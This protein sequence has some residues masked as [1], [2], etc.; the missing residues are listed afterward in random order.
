MACR[1]NLRQ[2][3][4]ALQVY[5]AAYDGKLPWVQLF[6]AYGGGEGV[7][8]QW[9]RSLWSSVDYNGITLCPMAT[10]PGEGLDGG[11]FQAWQDMLPTRIEGVDRVLHVTGSYGGNRSVGWRLPGGWLTPDLWSWQTLLVKGTDEI[12]FFFDCV[13]PTFCPSTVSTKGKTYDMGLPPQ[14]EGLKDTT[15]YEPTYKVCINRHEGGINM[16][17]LDGG[18]R[19]VG[20]KELWTLRWHRSYDTNNGWTKRGGVKPEDWPEWMRGFKDY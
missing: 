10:R 15:A 7:V 17:F 18:V 9:H 14:Q 20:L 8:P 5:A 3:G 12:P 16:V 13:G 4:V 6:G 11:T 19:K 1:A 2:W